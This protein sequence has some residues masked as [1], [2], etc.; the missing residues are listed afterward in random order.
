MLGAQR[1][2]RVVD[3]LRASRVILLL[4]HDAQSLRLTLT[5]VALIVT[6]ERSR[7]VVVILGKQAH[8]FIND[9][10]LLWILI[11]VFRVQA[12]KFP[13]GERCRDIRHILVR[14]LALRSSPIRSELNWI[15]LQSTLARVVLLHH[16][17][18]NEVVNVYESL[19]IHSVMKDGALL[20][21]L[22]DLVCIYSTIL[23]LGCC[24]LLNDMCLLDR[25]FDLLRYESYESF[26]IR[27]IDILLVISTWRVLIAQLLQRCHVVAAK[28]R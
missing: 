20:L 8:L 16:I 17:K 6:A 11:D 22:E 10:M 18:R 9:Q 26:L 21:S 14:A 1:V 4:D 5:L 15:E 25:A 2:G 24:G 28:H 23:L 12:S 19:R 13:A 3:A 7:A 27:K